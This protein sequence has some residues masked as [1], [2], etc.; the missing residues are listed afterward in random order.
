MEL[1]RKYLN[2]L[3]TAFLKLNKLVIY[4]IIDYVKKDFTCVSQN[5]TS[6]IE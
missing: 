5:S 4:R 2:N 3:V 1:N 6:A